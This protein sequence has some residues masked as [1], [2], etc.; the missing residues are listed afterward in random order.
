MIS[1]GV[2]IKMNDSKSKYEND[3]EELIFKIN[4]LIGGKSDEA[5][6]SALLGILG[7]CIYQETLYCSEEDKKK[8]TILLLTIDGLEKSYFKWKSIKESGGR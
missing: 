5:A 1:V 8:E 2:F 6:I 7:R 3:F 4:D